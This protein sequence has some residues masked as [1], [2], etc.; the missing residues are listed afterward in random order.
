MMTECP[1]CGKEIS[2]K[3]TI[4][5]HCGCRLQLCTEC[6]RMVLYGAAACPNCGYRMG[7]SGAE[8]E[9]IPAYVMNAAGTLNA[10]EL[11]NHTAKNAD[12]ILKWVERGLW[13]LAAC[14]LAVVIIMVEQIRMWADSYRQAQALELI[15]LWLRADKF[16]KIFDIFLICTAICAA[17]SSM[18][19]TVKNSVVTF[20]LCRDAAKAD[21]K[22]YFRTNKAETEKDIMH[23]MG[24]FENIGNDETIENAFFFSAYPEEKKK[25]LAM[26]IVFLVFYA[27]FFLFIALALHENLHGY[28][29]NVIVG[30]GFVFKY[31]YTIVTGAVSVLAIVFAAIGDSIFSRKKKQYIKAL[32]K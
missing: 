21:P 23:G 14:L 5:V 8:Q 16:L 13:I 3:A 32:E 24:N 4:C 12:T 19:A 17:L 20:L 27:L 1:E 2:N 29:E 28:V 18:V 10:W 6:G 31:V 7:E 15:D 25:W 22:K 11:K 26:Q 30:K 9:T